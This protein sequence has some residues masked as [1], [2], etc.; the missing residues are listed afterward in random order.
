MF[1]VSAI[2]ILRKNSKLNLFMFLVSIVRSLCCYA[3]NLC[4]IDFVRFVPISSSLFLSLALLSSLRCDC[5]LC[6]IIF[7]LTATVVVQVFVNTFE[8]TNKRRS[9]KKK[10]AKSVWCKEKL[11]VVWVHS[12]RVWPCRGRT[13]SLLL[14][15]CEINPLNNRM[16]TKTTTTSETTGDSQPK[17]VNRF[18]I[19]NL[20]LTLEICRQ[21][22]CYSYII[23]SSFTA[24]LQECVFSTLYRY[25]SMWRI[26]VIGRAH[27]TWWCKCV[28]VD[29]SPTIN[30]SSII[31]A[32]TFA[33]R[34][35]DDFSI[36]SFA[37]ILRGTSET[38]ALKD[39][40][41]TEITLSGAHVRLNGNDFAWES[42]LSR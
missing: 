38:I 42:W 28:A 5:V 13:I 14:S 21:T 3:L 35:V 7:V 16:V 12:M 2:S 33:P 31:F 32:I 41:M 26:R 9:K 29:C 10:C 22:L 40:E 30:S 1:C 39:W 17:S 19:R 25:V 36:S 8:Q 37:H 34:D 24:R 11:T 23:I 4:E 27:E 18:D 6:T 15:L 20:L